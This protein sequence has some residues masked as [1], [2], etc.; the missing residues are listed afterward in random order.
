MITL[1]RLTENFQL[2]LLERKQQWHDLNRTRSLRNR[3]PKGVYLPQK[4][5]EVSCKRMNG[6]LEIGTY[7]SHQREESSEGV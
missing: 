6:R 2:Q 5:I 3:A 7:W 1:R 4:E